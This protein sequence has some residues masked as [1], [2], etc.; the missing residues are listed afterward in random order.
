MSAPFP[1]LTLRTTLYRKVQK[2]VWRIKEKSNSGTVQVLRQSILPFSR[3]DFKIIF[4]FQFLININSR[5]SDTVFV[6]CQ[7][8]I[9]DTTKLEL[10][11]FGYCVSKSIKL[12]IRVYFASPISTF[13]FVLPK[14]AYSDRYFYV[15]THVRWCHFFAKRQ[16]M[17]NTLL[18]NAK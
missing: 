9:Y 7:T 5:F 13:M 8:N 11:K 4:T 1:T 2:S 15:Y 12:G 3:K 17:Q 6:K 10:F 14:F 18:K 16:C